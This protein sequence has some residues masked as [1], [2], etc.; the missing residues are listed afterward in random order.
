MVMMMMRPDGDRDVR[1]MN[2]KWN[3]TAVNFANYHW[4]AVAPIKS[5]ENN[6]NAICNTCVCVFV[7]VYVVKE[8]N[9]LCFYGFLLY[10]FGRLSWAHR[11]VK[12]WLSCVAVVLSLYLM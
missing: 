10:C 7:C 8:E 4:I 12:F 3:E 6:V 2:E 11:L 5:Q 9:T 1:A